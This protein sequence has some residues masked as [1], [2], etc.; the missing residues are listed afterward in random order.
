MVWIQ[1]ETF[2][3]EKKKKKRKKKSGLLFWSKEFNRNEWVGGA[4]P[5]HININN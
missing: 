4:K 1:I 3:Y 5:F 2:L